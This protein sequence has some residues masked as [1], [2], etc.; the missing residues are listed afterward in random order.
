M[1]WVHFRKA[2]EGGCNQISPANILKIFLSSEYPQLFF[3]PVECESLEV[4]AS[5][6][7]DS[8]LVTKLCLE[9]VYTKMSLSKVWTKWLFSLLGITWQDYSFA[10]LMSLVSLLQQMPAVLHVWLVCSE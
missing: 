8:H 7:D 2:W 5:S 4:K 6:G 9:H 10:P 1:H 3:S